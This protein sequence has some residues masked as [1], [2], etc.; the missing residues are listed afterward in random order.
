MLVNTICLDEKYSTTKLLCKIMNDECLILNEDGRIKEECKWNINNSE[1]NIKNSKLIGNPDDK[2]ETVLFLPE[3]EGRKGEGGLRAKGYFK[4]SYEDKPLISIITVV[5]NGE[6][7]L[8]E[9]IQSI[10]NQTY[11]NVEYIIIDGG[12]TD[13]TVNIIKKYEDKIDYWVSEK[14][15]GIYDAWNKAIICSSGEWIGFLGADDFYIANALET[16]VHEIFK[17]KQVDYLSSKVNLCDSKKESLRIV[18]SRWNWKSFSRYMNVA[19]V[20]SLHQ[21]RLYT[22]FGLYDLS[23]KICGDYELLLRP[24][25]KLK[26]AFINKVLAHMRIGGVSDSSLKVFKETYNAKTKHNTRKVNLLAKIDMYISILKWKLRKYYYG[27]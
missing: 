5:Y 27:Y 6:K 11:D 9:T 17:N 14:D 23:F 7:Y 24:Q 22:D 16:Y 3:V 12:S 21:R 1:F 13:G 19:H 2:F 8:E 26:V 25:Y 10:V 18:G 4:K 15:R 20:G